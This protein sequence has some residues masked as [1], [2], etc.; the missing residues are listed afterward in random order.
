MA[1]GAL[2]PGDSGL[3]EVFTL[4][5]FLAG[6]CPGAVP[7]SGDP[8]FG[9]VTRDGQALRG[10]P[11]HPFRPRHQPGDPRAAVACNSCLSS[12]ARLRGRGG[13]AGAG[14]AEPRGN[15][16]GPGALRYKLGSL[17]VVCPRA[18]GRKRAVLREGAGLIPEGPE[19]AG[20]VPGRSAPGGR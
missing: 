19:A 1:R 5:S 18:P 15:P 6:P 8:G 7:G 12:E 10:A 14:W 3:L 4:G 20:G 11:P 2:L 9:G 13:D 17:C 16:A